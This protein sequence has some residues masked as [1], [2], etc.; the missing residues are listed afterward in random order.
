MKKSMKL[1]LT[2]VL[3]LLFTVAGLVHVLAGSNSIPDAQENGYLPSE[4]IYES[5]DQMLDVMG[6][7][8]Y[9]VYTY[10]LQAGGRVID[11][12]SDL[13]SLADWDVVIIIQEGSVALWEIQW[14]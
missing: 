7:D 13:Y 11:E 5:I 4:E 14:R 1:S 10:T 9:A 3:M 2:G 8:Q 12:Y 6:I